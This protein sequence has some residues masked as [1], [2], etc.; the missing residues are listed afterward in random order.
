[1]TPT[2]ALLLLLAQSPSPAH[3]IYAQGAFL[4]TDQPASSDTYHRV[5]PNLRGHAAGLSISGG[6]WFHGGLALEG[7]FAFSGKVSDSQEFHYTFQEYYTAENV[8]LLFNALLRVS[9]HRRSAIEGVFGGGIART[10]AGFTG[11]F[12]DYPGRPQ[13]DIPD[14]FE[15]VH[16]WT[17]T[18]GVDGM[19]RTGTAAIMVPS[20]RVRYIQRPE[21]AGLG[22][23]GVGAFVLQVGA[24]VRF[25]G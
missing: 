6:A 18:A 25:G 24:G 13:F 10:R 19:V 5:T 14:R 9:P 20:V 7:E 2:L 11:K 12:A 16:N 1:M 3:R 21:P 23:T 8:D 17:L 22:W 4:L 15:T